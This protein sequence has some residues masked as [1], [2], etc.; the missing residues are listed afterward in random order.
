M[1]SA[2]TLRVQDTTITLDPC[3]PFRNGLHYICTVELPQAIYS[4]SVSIV[5]FL[6]KLSIQNSHFQTHLHNISMNLFALIYTPL[7]SPSAVCRRFVNPSFTVFPQNKHLF[8]QFSIYL[9]LPCLQPVG[10]WGPVGPDSWLAGW[11]QMGT[12]TRVQSR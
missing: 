7:K 5:M 10:L 3:A 1:D 12:N 6:C 2:G 9:F 8:I 11:L 4:H